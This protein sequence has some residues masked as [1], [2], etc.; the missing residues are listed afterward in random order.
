VLG[1][2]QVRQFTRWRRQLAAGGTQAGTRKLG[3][4]FR[5]PAASR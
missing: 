4:S 3:R 5:V 2:N 1:I